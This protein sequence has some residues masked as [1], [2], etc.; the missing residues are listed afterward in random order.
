MSLAPDRLRDLFAAASELEPAVQQR[1]LDRECA[2]EPEMRRALEDL[3]RAD[4]GAQSSTL[5]ERSALQFEARQTMA[6]Q[7]LPLERLGPYRILERIGAGGMGVVYLAEADYDGVRKQVAIKAIPW[8]F[9]PNMVR[10]FQQERRILAGLEHPNIARM[11][12]AGTDGVP[13][14]V[15]EYVDGLP[16]KRYAAEQSL[17]L[18]GRLKLFRQICDAVAYAHRKLIVHR[19]LKPGNILVTAEGVPKL[20]DFGI[21]Q[22]LD[23]S[24]AEATVTAM[25]TPHYAS[26][27]QRAG[28]P[29]TTA[30]DI[31]SLGVILGELVAEAP[32]RGNSKERSGLGDLPNVIAMARREEPERRYATAADLGEEIRRV[33]ERYPVR[34]R[35]DT[36]AYRFRRFVSRRPVEFGVTLA[37]IAMILVAGIV[38]LEQYRAANRRFQDVRDIANSFLF[39]VNDALADQPGTT[40]ARAIIA[41]R[42]Q[43]YLDALARDRS[44]DRALR[45]EVAVAYRK[46]GDIQGQPFAANLGDTAGALRNYRTSAQILEQ[47]TAAGSRDPSLYAALGEVY[48]RQGHIAGRMGA[49]AE[50]IAAATK[51]MQAREKAVALVPSSVEAQ[52]ALVDGRLFLALCHEQAGANRS[53]I[54]EM[55]IAE[56]LDAAAVSVASQWSAEKN[57]ADE[58]LLLLSKA[59]EFAAYQETDLANATGNRDYFM[60]ALQ[61]HR[62]EADATERLYR[63]NPGRYRR[64]WADAQNDLSRGWLA[65][66]DARKSETAAREGLRVFGEIA[67]GDPNNY[68]AARDVFLAHWT[69]G[70]SLAAQN[71]DATGEFQATLD[72]YEQAHRLNPEDQV[73]GVLVESRDWLA[74]HALAAGNGTEAVAQYRRN[75][76]LLSDRS[77]EPGRRF[78]AAGRGGIVST[79][80]LAL[81]E[82]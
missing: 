80:A 28:S 63:R 22:L 52:R 8:S 14:L 7:Q 76:K 66:G 40:K 20:L 13:Y 33:M 9:D 82:A 44:S 32:D 26:P 53:D 25:M 71:R 41:E 48:D 50:S 43:R 62:Q 64:Y 2:G 56:A 17:S 37:L 27:E 60:R 31:Y 72:G 12:D 73:V 75:I 47:M 6:A 55:K 5:W 49:F 11:L 16:L 19:D 1:W 23:E 42:A 61:L 36:R 39:E 69:L 70:K 67:A 65:V 18:T 81:G 30:S 57:P 4:R 15:M 38:A 3:L 24:R 59:S 29:I 78:A 35:P 74:G 51:S 54:A 21:A 58:S 34:A 77:G 45:M 46:L 68:E 79:G 10:R